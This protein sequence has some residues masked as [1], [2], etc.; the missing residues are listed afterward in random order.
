M[1]SDPKC[2]RERHRR[3]CAEW[4]ER[5]P[6]YDREERLRKKLRPR[7]EEPRKDPEVD[8]LGEIDWQAARDAVGTESSI[9]VE[10]TQKVV[11]AWLRDAVGAQTAKISLELAQQLNKRSRDEIGAPEVLG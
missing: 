6:D 11:A 8:P 1:C 2:Q 7:Q 5:H 3:S 4:H 10:E 9:F